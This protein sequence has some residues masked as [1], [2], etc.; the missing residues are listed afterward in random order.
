MK[1][2]YLSALEIGELVN[3][4]KITPTEVLKYFENRIKE[5]NKSINAFTYTRFDLAYIEAKKLE[6]RLDKGEY[7]GIFAGVPFGLKDFLPSKKGW[8]RSY[9]GVKCLQSIDEYDSLFCEVMESEGAIAV[10]KTNA[11]SYGF[12]GT[13]DNKMYGPTSTPFNTLY[14]AG[15]S[16]GGSASAVSDG[17]LPISEGGDAGG[18]IRVPASCCNLVGFKPGFG[19]IPLYS[20]PD[21][22]SASHPYCVGFGLVKTVSDAIAL[23]KLMAKANP[24]D[25]YNN[26]VLRQNEDIDKYIFSN[27]TLKIGFTYDFDLFE[28]DEE[29]KKI[30]YD[31][32]KRFEEKGYIVEEVHFHFK[33][34]ANEFSDLWCK[35]ITVDCAIDINQQ[36]E[37]GIDYLK[38]N[39]EDFPEE[40]IY[41]KKICD[42][43]GILDLY[44]FNL[45]RTDILDNF[46]DV[47]EKYDLII[48]PVTCCKPVKNNLNGFTKGPDAINGKKVDSLIGWCQTYLA[49]FVSYPAIS[50]PAG[51]AK[52]NLPI[53]MQIVG[54]RFEEKMVLKAALDFESIKP[55][56]DNFQIPFNREIKEQ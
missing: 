9:G 42:Q 24:R 44:Q 6:E 33:H 27:K 31:A 22:Y 47:F 18:S 52:H 5:R 45:A 2:E 56:K 4:K 14:N 13:T 28:V 34:T 29:V 10:G 49:N 7:L 37:K 55:W 48:S 12:S 26:M 8:S 40:F 1:L 38:D 30:V 21:A 11:P 3:S 32:A 16:S 36:K 43:L 41:Y 39:I 51:I 20:R 35:G 46:E 54:K 15:G 53:G 50:I 19:S 25:P 23:Y 17:L